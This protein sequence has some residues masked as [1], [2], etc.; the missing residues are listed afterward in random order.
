M[1]E[2][3]I[4]VECVRLG[5]SHSFLGN[6]KTE[7]KHEPGD[8]PETPVSGSKQLEPWRQTKRLTGP[9]SQKQ[10][11]L[12]EFTSYLLTPFDHCACM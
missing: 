11:L 8:K 12:N 5:H 4:L 2:G 7:S 3:L 1:L 9:N 6:K 10:P